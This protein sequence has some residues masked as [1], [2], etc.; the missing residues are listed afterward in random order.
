MKRPM[1]RDADYPIT[2]DSIREAKAAMYAERAA[3]RLAT[4]V[5]IDAD[6]RIVE[7]VAKKES[8]HAA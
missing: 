1:R 3:I 5:V 8:V 7:T 6:G 2:A 4:G